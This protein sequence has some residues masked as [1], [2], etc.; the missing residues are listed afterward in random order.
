MTIAQAMTRAALETE[1]TWAQRMLE[2][3]R[4]EGTSIVLASTATD[5]ER[6]AARDSGRAF[7]DDHGSY[8]VV[9]ADRSDSTPAQPKGI[10]NEVVGI[11]IEDSK[12]LGDGLHAVPIAVGAGRQMPTITE[13]IAFAARVLG[14]ARER[15]NAIDL[16]VG[17]IRNAMS[18]LLGAQ[19]GR[20]GDD[21]AH[22]DLINVATLAVLLDSVERKA[23]EDVVGMS[24]ARFERMAV[25]ADLHAVGADQFNL[26]RARRFAEAYRD[27]ARS[28][29]AMTTNVEVPR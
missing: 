28:L 18:H 15:P 27:A 6:R 19:G 9:R 1:W 29:R 17:P 23:R 24:A 7:T 21:P 3:L 13:Y 2:R 8:L 10:R 11:A 5:E 12:P 20:F 16:S 25:D 14:I 4:E 22:P 26:D